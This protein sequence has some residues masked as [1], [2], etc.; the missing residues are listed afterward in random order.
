M[1]CQPL[2]MGISKET[3]NLKI[4]DTTHVH[5]CDGKTHSDWLCWVAWSVVTQ[6]ADII[7]SYDQMRTKKETKLLSYTENIN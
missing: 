3:S 2:C 4:D 1:M 6:L 5:I 7:S